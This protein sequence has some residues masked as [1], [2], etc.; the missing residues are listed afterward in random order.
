MLA[1]GP[2]QAG[3][4]PMPI[5]SPTSVS[6]P[7]STPDR[8]RARMNQRV[9]DQVWS[10]VQRDYYDPSIHGL[11]WR[12]VRATYRP[13]A[14]AATS[15]GAL[16]RVL[17]RMLDLLN[18]DHAGVAAPAAVRRQDL[19]RER[20]PIMGVTLYPED[21]GVYRIE[22][23]RTGSPAEEAGIRVGWRLRP[24]DNRWSPDMDVV[25]GQAI[26]LRFVDDAGALH[27]VTV[28]P[29]EMDGLPAFVADRSRPGVLVLR[30]EGFEPGLGDWMGGQL[31]DLPADTDVVLDLRANPGGLLMEAD[32]VLSCFLPDRQ[33]WAT[34]TSRSGRASVLR[35]QPGCGS[36][37]AP[38]PNALAV[39]VDR[40]SRSAAELTPAALQEAGRAVIVGEKT[41]GAV[42]ISQDTRLA[43]GGRLTLSRAD[44]VTRGGIRL[45]KR[46][47]HPD[48][49]VA[50]ADEPASAA[51]P[52]PALDAA[53][54]T[55]RRRE[56]A[57]RASPP[58][59]PS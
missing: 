17:D 23:V 19:L 29:R 49:T 31:A 21:D 33:V 12:A 2:V 45:E 18:D 30:I 40:S 8:D 4:G 32:A 48:I 52:D 54:A 56:A 25:D 46:G 13:Q 47:V 26:A 36:L 37:E 6:A 41:A 5:A 16:Y 42:L 58:T 59:S 35:V 24:D 11:D 15:D 14:L 38:A 44:F 10:E 55:L 20:H 43:D 9:F 28:M 34:R 39:L 22:R 3:D 57:D 7:P 51:A 53:V 1:V 50:D 27:D